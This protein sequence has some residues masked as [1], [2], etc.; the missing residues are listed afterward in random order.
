MHFMIR[1]LIKEYYKYKRKVLVNEN[2]YIF[3]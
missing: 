3:L 2:L 1:L